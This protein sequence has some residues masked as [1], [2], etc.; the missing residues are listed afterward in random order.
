MKTSASFFP[1]L[2]HGI[3]IVLP[4]CACLGSTQLEIR[5]ASFTVNG[6]RTFMLGFSYYSGLGAPDD[7]V[8][9]DLDEAQRLG[10]NWLRLWATWNAFGYDVS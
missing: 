2:L 4:V 5:D 8:H 6:K 9:K 10:F 1:E 7:S 3:A